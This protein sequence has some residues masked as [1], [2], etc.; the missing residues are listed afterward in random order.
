MKLLKGTSLSRYRKNR[1]GGI[2]KRVLSA[3][4]D[5]VGVFSSPLVCWGWTNKRTLKNYDGNNEHYGRQKNR[6]R[7]RLAHHRRKHRR[8]DLPLHHTRGREPFG[9]GNHPHA[10]GSPKGYR[11]DQL[12]DRPSA[13]ALAVSL[14]RL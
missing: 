1:L 11:R 5:L 6:L 7:R 9:G 4:D 3:F 13:I 8:E 14:P 10:G 2:Q 12:G